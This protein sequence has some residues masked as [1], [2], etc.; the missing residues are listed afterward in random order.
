M[1][2]AL[3]KGHGDLFDTL[4]RLRTGSIYSHCELVIDECCYSS[5]PRDGG[6]RS[7]WI[8]LDSG[9]WDLVE[10]GDKCTELVLSFFEL[11]QGAKYDWIGAVIGRGL[12]VQIELRSRWFCSEWCAAALGFEQAWRFTPVKLL[13]AI[14]PQMAILYFPFYS[15]LF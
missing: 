3:Y 10:I 12:G 4:I 2:L 5:S 7:K 1:Q 11:T 15:V 8:D 9:N 13:A 14:L 6:V